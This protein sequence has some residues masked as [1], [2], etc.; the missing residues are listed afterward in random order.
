MNNPRASEFTKTDPGNRYLWRMNPIRLDSEV[1]RDSIL[2][3]SGE[4][5]EANVLH[6][7]IRQRPGDAIARPDFERRDIRPQV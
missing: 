3:I 4:L 2:A 7:L 1:I 5:N 6:L